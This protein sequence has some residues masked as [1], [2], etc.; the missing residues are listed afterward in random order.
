MLKIDEALPV[1]EEEYLE[2]EKQ[3]DIKHEYVNGN[4]VAMAGASANHNYVKDIISSI[5]IQKID[6]VNCRVMTSDQKVKMP[7]GN[8]RYS[9]VVV[10]CFPKFTDDKQLVLL[11]PS[12]LVEVLSPES[13]ARDKRDKLF[14]YINIPSLQHYLIV[15]PDVMEVEHYSRARSWVPLYLS[16]SEEIIS[17][18][19]IHLSV[20]LSEVYLGVLG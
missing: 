19:E 14:E 9:D 1:S 4:L 18:S 15:N 16:N 8:C 17:I 2:F 6:R 12:I 11:N 3:S 5:F 7:S 10:T 13:K 20:L